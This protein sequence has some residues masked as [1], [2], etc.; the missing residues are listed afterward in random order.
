MVIYKQ[1]LILW[2]YIQGVYNPTL[3]LA[4]YGFTEQD[5]KK[6]FNVGSFAGLNKSTATLSEIYQALRRV[7][8]NTI[9]FEYMH[10]NRS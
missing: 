6:T 2:D 8:C 3:E 9:G 10:I 4:Y 1:I 5:L 7:Y